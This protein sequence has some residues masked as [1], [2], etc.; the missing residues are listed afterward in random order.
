MA[1][2]KTHTN[3]EIFS[4]LCDITL[5]SLWND[6]FSSIN[7]DFGK[8]LYTGPGDITG[9]GSEGK[10]THQFSLYS[11][12]YI[13]LAGEWN[14]VELFLADAN[15]CLPLDVE[16]G[17]YARLR[18][19]Q[20]FIQSMQITVQNGY[21]SKTKADRFLGIQKPFL[22]VLPSLSPIIH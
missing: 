7:L 21:S 20:S 8:A 1:K 2:L 15:Q 12:K 9:E 3:D 18:A 19:L 14:Q 4:Y 10:M 13:D 5:L 6:K 16:A 11:A 22:S 17:I